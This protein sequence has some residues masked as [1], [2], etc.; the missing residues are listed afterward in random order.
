MIYRG[1]T[2][3]QVNGWFSDLV[4][5]GGNLIGLQRNRSDASSQLSAEKAMT[6]KKEQT[7]RTAATIG[8]IAL[9]GIVAVAMFSK[10]R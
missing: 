3:V 1:T 7:V 2:S 10:K 8:G 4:D 6:A 5:I 9:V